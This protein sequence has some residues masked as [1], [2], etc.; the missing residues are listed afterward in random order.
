LTQY[1]KNKSKKAQ[2]YFIGECVIYLALAPK[3]TQIQKAFS[4]AV[5]KAQKSSNLQP[6]DHLKIH[7]YSPLRQDYDS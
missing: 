7:G 3:T 2:Y 4:A 6:S 5:N 1:L